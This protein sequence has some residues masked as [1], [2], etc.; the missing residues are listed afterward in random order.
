MSS[1]QK[2]FVNEIKRVA[3]AEV[4]ALLKDL[5]KK[6]ADQS[7]EIKALTATIKTMGGEVVAPAAPPKAAELDLTLTPE[8]QALV[9]KFNKNTMIDLARKS[10]L[11]QRQIAMLLGTSLVSVSKWT[12][13]KALPR[14][15]MKAAVVELLSMD[16]AAIIAR[17]PEE[18]RENR[19]TRHQ[20]A[21][22]SK[23]MV[24]AAKTR[25]RNAAKGAGK[26]RKARVKKVPSTSSISVEDA[27]KAV[28][29]IMGT[30][31]SE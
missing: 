3:H 12:S 25:S 4:N 11:T 10:G 31:V 24:K 18:A 17:L 1:L 7:R 14:D 27:A 20:K 30:P 15:A 26:I 13:G 2:V 9:E 6:V 19:K 21:V 28:A 5:R 22:R 16:K 8:R 29:D 23:A